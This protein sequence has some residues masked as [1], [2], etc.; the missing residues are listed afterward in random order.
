MIGFSILQSN[1]LDRMAKKQA[2]PTRNTHFSLKTTPYSTFSWQTAWYL[3]LGMRKERKSR[4][5]YP[6]RLPLQNCRKTANEYYGIHIAFFIKI[7][8]EKI[9]QIKLVSDHIEWIIK[10]D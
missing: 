9:A 1:A 6:W 2:I 5:R 10:N 7:P 4:I 8:L 3:C